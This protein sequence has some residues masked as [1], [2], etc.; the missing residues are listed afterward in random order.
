MR[1]ISKYH[2]YYDSVRQYGIDPKLVYTREEVTISAS[3]NKLPT[4]LRK[5]IDDQPSYLADAVLRQ[6]R[7]K[8]HNDQSIYPAIVC[9]CNKVY[10]MFRTSISNEYCHS[11]EEVIAVVKKSDH[12][13][14]KSILEKI[15]KRPDCH[16]EAWQYDKAYMNTSS[17][18]LYLNRHKWELEDEVFVEL[19]VPYFALE[20]NYSKGIVLTLNPRLLT[21]GFQR[22]VD[23]YT[24]YQQVSMFVG[25][26]LV[27][28]MD[29]NINITNNDRRDSAGFDKWSFRKKVR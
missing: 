18:P 2:D 6:I 1:I 25:N 26:N 3:Y 29:P 22:L 27:K 14:K 21:Y 23:P 17:W 16:R 15:T 5:M 20:E 28:Q 11:I 13:N 8:F 4:R 24:A 7:N 12:P 9:F 10:P 19:G